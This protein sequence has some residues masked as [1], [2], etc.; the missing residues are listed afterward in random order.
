[1]SGLFLLLTSCVSTLKNASVGEYRRPAQ[2]YTD[3]DDSKDLTFSELKE[4]LQKN[5]F[6]KIEDLLQYL[7]KEKPD[8]MSRYTLGYNSKSLHVSSTEFPRAIVFGTSAKT[9]LTF[10]GSPKQRNYEMLEVAHFDEKKERYEFLEIEFNERGQLGQVPHRFSEEG[11]PQNICLKCHI[12]HQPLWHAYAIW[13]GFYGTDD[14][15]PV[16]RG[17][18]NGDGSFS[19]LSLVP[20]TQKKIIREWADFKS[21]G[22]KKGRY[23]HLPSMAVSRF[24]DGEKQPRPNADFTHALYKMNS[25]RISRI[26]KDL[27]AQS[28]PVRSLMLYGRLCQEANVA[29]QK[30]VTVGAQARMIESHYQSFKTELQKR[31]VKVL[32][33]DIK[34]ITKHYKVSWK[35]IEARLNREYKSVERFEDWEPSQ[36]QN[37]E[38]FYLKMMKTFSQGPYSI[39]SFLHYP[40]GTSKEDSFHFLLSLLDKK[41]P[42]AQVRTWPMNFYGDYVFD[43]GVT[44]FEELVE[45]I[46]S[47]VFSYIPP[48]EAYRLKALRDTYVSSGDKLDQQ[49]YSACKEF[50]QKI[51]KSFP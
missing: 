30:D 31:R 47:T 25:L 13:P 4:I 46:D 22:M 34:E 17:K 12:N 26:L 14:D 29:L 50:L 2:F 11:G 28:E 44:A 1:M 32:L 42:Q 19:F 37:E 41:L 21:D 18:G 33:D 35:Q 36:S 8:Y 7:R 10:N 38:E 40:T 9:I 24:D 20:E 49:E 27:G 48:S 43:D 6:S 51:I 39:K 3:L 45:T 5:Q 15:F 16:Y 23:Q